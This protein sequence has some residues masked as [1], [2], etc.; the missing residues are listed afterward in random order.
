MLLYHSVWLM[1]CVRNLVEDGC[2]FDRGD[3]MLDTTL[4]QPVLALL[5]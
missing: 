2:E 1:L 3:M 5:N 4:Y